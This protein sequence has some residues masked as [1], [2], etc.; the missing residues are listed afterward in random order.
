MAREKGFDV[1]M[2]GFE[3]GMKQ[4]KER[5]RAAATVETQDWIVLNPSNE[6]TVFLGYESL[7]A[8]VKPVKYRKVT[9]KGKTFTSLYLIKL[10]FM[11][12][13]ADR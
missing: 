2:K 10:H 1:D 12:N 4:Q 5:S 8:E 7:Q 3:S 6:E 11:L 13:Q 9:S